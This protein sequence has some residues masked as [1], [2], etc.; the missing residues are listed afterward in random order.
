MA[1]AI[2]RTDLMSGTDDRSQLVSVKYITNDTPTAIDNGNVLK[3]DGLMDNEREIF[4]GVAPA[5]STALHDVVLVASPEVMYDERLRNFEEYENEAGKACRGYRL[6]SGGIF[7]VTKEALDGVD[8][9]AAGD[10][11]ELAAST[12]LNVVAAS[13]GAT[14]GSTVVGKIHDV[15]VVGSYTFYAIL[16][17]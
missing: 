15:N 16:I 11:V 5:V 17:D 13:V 6:H 10:I 12:K 9:P 14:S 8:E 3:L 2:V 4:K 1:H 7:S